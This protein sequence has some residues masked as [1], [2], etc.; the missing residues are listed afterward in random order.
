MNSAWDVASV[1][2]IV[3]N[4]NHTETKFI[5][6]IFVTISWPSCVF[7]VYMWSIFHFHPHFHYNQSYNLTLAFY[8]FLEDLKLFF[9]DKMCDEVNNFQIAK[10]QYQMLLSFFLIF[11]KFQ[12]GVAYKSVACKKSVYF[13][14]DFLKSDAVVPLF[15]I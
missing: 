3:H 4:H 12:P 6:S 7:V 10:V 9:D 2:L 8:T 14:L 15:Y 1:L 11:C 5:L 13:F